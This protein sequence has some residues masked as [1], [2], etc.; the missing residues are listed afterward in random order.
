MA[1]EEDGGKGDSGN[2]EMYEMQPTATAAGMASPDV[3][4]SEAELLDGKVSLVGEGDR[5]GKGSLR[6]GINLLDATAMVIGGIIG[7]GIFI[8]PAIILELTGSFGVSMLCWIAG[9][10]ISV[11]GGLCFVEL[12]LLLPRTG[13]AMVYILEA[14]SFKDRN[15]R[16]RLLGRLLAFV[17]TWAAIVVIRPTSLCIIVLTCTRYLTRPFYLD[18]DIPETL[19]KCLALAIFGMFNHRNSILTPLV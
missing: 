18:C 6:R 2:G 17:Y 11:C 10:A 4:D 8:T 16:T 15:E 14:F 1:D 13:G 9:T 19:R 5:G 7:S 3:T 12:A